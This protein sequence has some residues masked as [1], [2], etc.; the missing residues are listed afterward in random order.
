MTSIFFKDLEVY[1]YL[2]VYDFEQRDGQRFIL[3][4]EG[5]YDDLLAPK[6]DELT[7]AVDYT[8]VAALIEN[9]F[10]KS[11]R[12]LLEIAVRELIDEIF[13][14]FPLL[15][16]VSLKVEK[17]DAKV[18]M[19]FDSFGVTETRRVEKVALSLGSNMGDKEK[20]ISDAIAAIKANK[21]VRNV[22]ASSFIT[23]KPYGGVEQEDFLNCAMTFD[24]WLT[25]RELFAFTAS[26]EEKA[27]RKREIHWGPRTLDIDIIL[28]G[29][30]VISDEDLCIPH[31]DM[32]N[33]GFVIE[34]LKEIAP[35]MVHPLLKKRIC[36]IKDYV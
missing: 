27:K 3:N 4:F 20:Y 9:Y 34:P 30:R 36:E 24:T 21:A 26:L 32:A 28:F 8:A 11:K 25:P 33:R 5:K 29:S 15:N 23:T 22:K 2:G 17:P 19:S 18:D 13:I 16:E 12:A 10:K 6:S 31:V 14:G 35:Y 7:E 1:G